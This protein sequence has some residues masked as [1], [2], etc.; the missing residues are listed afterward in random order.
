MAQYK[1]IEDYITFKTVSPDWVGYDNPSVEVTILRDKY[2]DTEIKMLR[3]CISEALLRFGALSQIPFN[4][5]I[6]P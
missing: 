2:D 4:A 3:S 5:E 6:K 1:N